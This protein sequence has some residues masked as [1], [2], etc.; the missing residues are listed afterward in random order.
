MTTATKA[1]KK[2]KPRQVMIKVIEAERH[3]KLEARFDSREEHASTIS[4]ARTA[5]G[6]DNEWIRDYMEENDL[7]EYRYGDYI[8][9][10]EEGETELVIK[11]IKEPKPESK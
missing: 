3:P 9:K 2:A 4:K 7:E 8:A 11:K 6:E 1:R 10:F 5:L